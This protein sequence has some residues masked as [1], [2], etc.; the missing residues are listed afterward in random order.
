MA[1]K[2]QELGERLHVDAHPGVAGF[3]GWSGIFR[4]GDPAS[5]PDSAL[6]NGQNIRLD[7]KIFVVRGGQA[8]VNSVT[9]GNL[10]VQGFFD[11]TDV[12]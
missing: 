9:L 11:A 12:S 8:K 10:D 5:I 6:W 2:I 3:L 4:A 1:L 7:G